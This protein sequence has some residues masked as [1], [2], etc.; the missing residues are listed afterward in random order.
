MNQGREAVNRNFQNVA[1]K[2]QSM[3]GTFAEKAGSMSGQS[4]STGTEGSRA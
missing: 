2:V 4:Q 3:A 1:G